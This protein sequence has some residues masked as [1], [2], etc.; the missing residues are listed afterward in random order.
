MQQ[1]ITSD[2][3]DAMRA[4]D[5]LRLTT[6]RMLTA[7]I[8]QFSIDRPSELRD[9]P[10]NDA[11]VLQIINK[12]IKQRKDSYEQFMRG[13]A[14]DRAAKEQLE[15]DIL[16]GYLPEQLSEDKLIALVD[17]AIAEVGAESIRDMGK[18]MNLAK[19]RAAGKVDPAVL[20]QQV[21]NRLSK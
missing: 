1:Q 20:S 4:K 18:V 8:K 7:A 14:D 15:I 2:V 19:E 3:K 12:M 5:S 10:V 13:G 11:E 6:L 17:A 16:S 21:K 9:A